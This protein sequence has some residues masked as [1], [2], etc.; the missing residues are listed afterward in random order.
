MKEYM[1]E[2]L[3]SDEQAE[4]FE[5][6]GWMT[7]DH[8]V[9]DEEGIAIRNYVLERQ[10]GGLMKRAGIGRREDFRVSTAQRGDFIEWIDP[11]S[12]D[13]V[14]AAFIA[15]M[16]D[17]MLQ[18]NRTFY[19]GISE[20]ET[21]F[22]CYPEGTHYERHRDRHQTGSR[23]VVSAVLYL[24]PGWVQDHGGELMI[25]PEQGG[26]AAIAPV[27]GRLAVFLSELEHEVK[28]TAR[29]RVSITGWMLGGEKW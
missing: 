2:R 24:N 10:R 8:F 9:S 4:M 6:Q 1:E 23:R 22:T 19:L 12:P 20:V 15:R 17:L 18:L 26:E 29:P 21:H 16:K 11:D 13:P 28:L 5:T 3:F 7:L 14:V 25:Y 27:F